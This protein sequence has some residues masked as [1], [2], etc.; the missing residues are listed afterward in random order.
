M[1][2]FTENDLRHSA[3]FLHKLNSIDDKI[4]NQVSN[5]EVGV[6]NLWA[7]KYM[8][9]W[10]DTYDG[11]VTKGSDEY[12][13][14]IQIEEPDIWNY[15]ANKSTKTDIFGGKIKFEE[16]KQYCFKVKWR[17]AA[18]EPAENWGIAFYI[19]YTDGS[20]TAFSASGTVCNTTEPSIKMLKT[21]STKTVASIGT[22]YNTH[23]AITR[24]YE[25]QLVQATKQPNDWMVAPEDLIDYTDTSI[26]NIKI[27]GRNLLLNS[28]SKQFRV[29][30]M[31]TSPTISRDSNYCSVTANSNERLHLYMQ[32][33]Q[34]GST[35]YTTNILPS[36][37]QWK[38]RNLCMSLEVYSPVDTEFW[39]AMVVRIKKEGSTSYTNI[40]GDYY[41]TPKYIKAVAESWTQI[42]SIDDNFE[43]DLDGNI[44]YDGV[45][46]PPSE[47]GRYFILS[48][49]SAVPEGV[50]YKLRN[51][52]LEF[53]NKPTDWS[54]APEDIDNRMDNLQKQIDGEISSWFFEGEPTT[55]NI[56]ANEW[57][58]DELKQRHEGD[59]YTD[60]NNATNEHFNNPDLWENGSTKD[61]IGNTY[62]QDKTASSYRLRTKELL[63]NN[64]EKITILTADWQLFIQYYNSEEKLAVTAPYTTSREL[65]K[66]YPYYTIILKKSDGNTAI[67]PSMIS[68]L[69]I[70]V[71]GKS[72]YD[73]TAGQSWRWCNVDD[74][75]GTGWHW[76]KIADS[77]AVKALAEAAKAQQLANTA[78]TTADTALTL[79]TEVREDKQDKITGT[80]QNIL[81]IG[82]DGV[83]SSPNLKY[84]ASTN[85]LSTPKINVGG[86]ALFTY[87]N[88]TGCLE[89]SV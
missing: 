55:S 25:I 74:E 6:R 86:G 57:T 45:S 84:N 69:S 36:T 43:Y 31:N 71:E 56:P 11:T 65:N 44:I 67:T 73:P 4:S 18:T 75:Y 85:T 27:G 35:E 42:Y 39:F 72:D 50:E 59:T 60:I 54:P 81:Y 47:V 53:G 52:K 10:N 89:I 2:A 49:K 1:S 77:D 38:N 13:E 32:I 88:T 51:L 16:G 14:Y 62:E 78:K 79:A 29:W 76:H 3:S 8:M 70:V 23:L 41:K 17:N 30:S 64:G 5:I 34:Q 80:N 40:A 87:N 58:T 63:K 83:T 37:Y 21:D 12:G 26:D 28:K 82:T 19:N 46:Y 61:T 24:I 7:K 68:T 9:D 33:Q 48:S 15:I 66:S 20:Q 22:T